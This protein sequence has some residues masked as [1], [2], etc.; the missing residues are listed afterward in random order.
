MRALGNAR[1]AK[2]RASKTVR[3]VL[4]FSGLAPRQGAPREKPAAA[5]ACLLT[6]R[7]DSS[8]PREARG[9][10]DR[11]G[12]IDSATCELGVCSVRVG[13]AGLVVY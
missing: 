5:R 13:L 3:P 12:L 4:A 11:L 7:A 1:G 10:R 9:G 2:K 8:T 6:L